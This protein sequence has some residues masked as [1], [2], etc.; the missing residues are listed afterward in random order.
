MPEPVATTVAAAT[1]ANIFP[2][3]LLLLFF[4]VPPAHVP[5]GES[6]VVQ[7][8]KGVW[9]LQSTSQIQTQNP[10]MCISIAKKMMK[11]V[12]PVNTL[13]VRA[14][15]LCPA[16]NGSN[17]CFNDDEHA[18]AMTMAITKPAAMPRPTVQTIGPLTPDPPLPRPPGAPARE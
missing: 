16:G 2:T 17:L 13:T 6:K 8:T 10:D 9:T 11:E 5:P 15:C 4:V 1:A 7:E 12:D 14:Y 3:T 18:K